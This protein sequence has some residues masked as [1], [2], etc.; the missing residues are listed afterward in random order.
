LSNKSVLVEAI[1]PRKGTML[2][3]DGAGRGTYLDWE[4]FQ[5]LINR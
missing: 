5:G 3:P 4:S 2:T 1:A